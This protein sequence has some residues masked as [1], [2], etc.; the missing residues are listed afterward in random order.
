MC[1]EY[2]IKPLRAYIIFSIWRNNSIMCKMP[3]YKR[4]LSVLC[5]KMLSIFAFLIYY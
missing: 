4:E 5:K 1:I 2:H 3:I